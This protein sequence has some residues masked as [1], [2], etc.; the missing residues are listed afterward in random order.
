LASRPRTPGSIDA[1]ADQLRA[2]AAVFTRRNLFH[3]VRRAS[4][5]AMTEAEFE[6][7]L[8]RRLARAALPGLLPAA[9]ARRARAHESSR[10]R[11]TRFPEA[12]LVVDRTAILDLFVSSGV[13]DAARIAVVC[14]D[15]T[16]P[17]VVAR[18]VRQIRA[19]RRAPVLYLHDAATVIYPFT[20][21]PLAT[22]LE[23]R[24]AEPLE[25]ADLG[26]PPLGATARRFDDPSLAR[27]EPIL[28][29]EAIP[30]AT[31]LRYCAKRARSFIGRGGPRRARSR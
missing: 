23:H 10:D 28:E 25:Y 13:T 30:P 3:A 2:S 1:A 24:G 9:P 26:L 12:I 14:V 8:R 20:V 22:I 11:D 15:G 17:R 21:E 7:A 5:G 27:D 29:L 6:A 19:G 18:L 4:G 16:P 31:L